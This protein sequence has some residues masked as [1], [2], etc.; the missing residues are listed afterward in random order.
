[1]VRKSLVF[2]ALTLSMGSALAEER[3]IQLALFDPIQIFKRTDDIR[4]LRLNFLYSMNQNVAGLDFGPVARVG[5]DFKGVQWSAVGLVHGSGL[6]WQAGWIANITEGA[7]KGLQTGGF[8]SAGSGKL[9]QFGAVNYGKNVEGFQLGFVN[10]AESLHGLQI[11]F[12]N[13]IKSKE[14]LPFLPIANWNF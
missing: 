2:L 13:V 14:K 9:F 7:F 5:G 10:V 3:V 12:V 11:G 1:M 6:G 4:G 8:N